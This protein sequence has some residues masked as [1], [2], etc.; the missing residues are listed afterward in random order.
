MFGRPAGRR[1]AGRPPPRCRRSRRSC[2]APGPGRARPGGLDRGQHLRQ[3]HGRRGALQRPPRDQRADARSDA[4]CQ[5]R[6]RERRHPDEEQPLAADR[7]AEPPADDEQ[8]G[9]RDRVPRDDQLQQPAGACR[10]RSMVGS[11]DVHD[12]E[13]RHRQE[14]ADEHG[15]QPERGQDGGLAL[16]GDRRGD[17]CRTGGL[18]NSRSHATS[19]RANVAWYQ[20]PGYPGTDRHL[21]IVHERGA[22]W[23]HGEQRDSG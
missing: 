12:E 9:V 2:R 14:H 22:R 13:V 11:G 18:V 10:S 1:A 8:Q 7:V 16:G 17:G 23:R 4:A 5:R 3:H 19:V 21:A 20:E 6:H 15:H